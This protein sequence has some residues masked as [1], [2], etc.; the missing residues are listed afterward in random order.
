ME[1]Q[2]V[3]KTTNNNEN[4]KMCFPFYFGETSSFLEKG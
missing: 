1:L 2:E 4:M 3:H